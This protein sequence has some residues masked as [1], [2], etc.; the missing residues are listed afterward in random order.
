MEKCCEDIDLNLILICECFECNDIE[1]VK[2]SRKI[3]PFDSECKGELS[4]YQRVNCKNCDYAEDYF[5]GW[6]EE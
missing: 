5:E 3:C 4:H 2:R 6:D 1:E